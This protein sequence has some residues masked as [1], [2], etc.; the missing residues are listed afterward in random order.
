MVR[1]ITASLRANGQ[2]KENLADAI[3]DSSVSGAPSW[4]EGQ[5][6]FS[7][8]PEAIAD[9]NS[10]KSMIFV[11][12]FPPYSEASKALKISMS[13]SLHHCPEARDGYLGISGHL[14]IFFRQQGGRPYN[15]KIFGSLLKA[16][17]SFQIKPYTI[18]T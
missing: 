1:E 11:S 17:D 7:V 3:R 2:L 10:N 16:G 4:F 14:A 12:G 6:G 15:Y 18:R 5:H 8:P 9:M 13:A